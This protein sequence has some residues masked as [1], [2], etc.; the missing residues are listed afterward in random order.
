MDKPK[1]KILLL[2][3]WVVLV[4][5]ASSSL[6]AELDS[7][8]LR[9]LLLPGSGQAHKGRYT[10][11]ALFVSAGVVSGVGL[12]ISQIHFNR[13]SERYRDE[14]NDY[15]DLTRRLE[16]G[17]V[18]RYDELT[19]TY[20]DMEEAH[21]QAIR[22]RKWRNGFLGVLIGTYVL[23]VVDIMVSSDGEKGLVSLRPAP[24]GVELAASIAF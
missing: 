22:R 10:K 3:T 18:V 24:G 5:T 1:A 6:A 7:A 11:A 2:S 13:A 12:F 19:S 17:Q 8:L 9:S 4:L 15:R 20:A 23:N 16:E 21:Q 14:V